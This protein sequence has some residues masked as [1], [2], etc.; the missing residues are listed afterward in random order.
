VHRD[1]VFETRTS[2]MRRGGEKRPLG[3]VAAVHVR[4]RGAGDD[5]E[6]VAEF[7]DDLQVSRQLE[8]AAGLGGNEIRLKK[9][10]AEIDGHHAAACLRLSERGGRQ[11]AFQK[12]QRKSNAAGAE[13]LTAGDWV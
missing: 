9:S 2:G 1:R 3:V 10:Q 7:L 4:M 6:L 8:V 11:Q 5:G 13:A 12:W